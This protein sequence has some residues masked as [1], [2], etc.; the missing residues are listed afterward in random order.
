VLELGC[1]TG[2]FTR[3]LVKT[4]ATVTAIDLSPELLELARQGLAAER[5]EFRLEDACHTSFAPGSFDVVLGS[6]V[7]HHLDLP[8]AL[9]EA[10]RVL[11]AGGV[12]RFTEPNMMNPQ[13]AVQK[14]VPFIKKRMGDSP[15]ETAFFRWSLARRLKAAG[16]SELS[17][18][19]FDFL[20]PAI[21]ASMLDGVESALA[22]LERVPLLRE[23]AGSLMIQARKPLS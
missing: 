12:L 16:F 23:I 8:A 4:G 21:P 20:H 5:L 10:Q 3:E 9:S 13:I 22:S 18:V 1:G 11:A 15:D 7:L 19:P 2:L 14:N 6:S 17:L